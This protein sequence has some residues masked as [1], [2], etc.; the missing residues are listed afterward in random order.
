MQLTHHPFQRIGAHAAA[1]L[2]G[3]RDCTELTAADLDRVAARIAADADRASRAVK[4]GPDW[5]W[6]VRLA[7]MYPQSPP[8]LPR[9]AV[10]AA[11]GRSV[12][13]DVLAQ[14]E[15]DAPDA[16]EPCWACG[17]AASVRWGK[18]HWPLLESARYYNT[19]RGGQP[20]CRECRIAVWALA[21]GAGGNGGRV[22]TVGAFTDPLLEA[23]I[24]QSRT[25]A[26]VAVI[27]S[28]AAGWPDVPVL[29]LVLSALVE[30]PGQI[31]IQSWSNGNREQVF[32]EYIVSAAA[33]GWL[34]AVWRLE[35]G[36]LL[37]ALAEAN[38]GHP[39]HYAQGEGLLLSEHGAEASRDLQVRENRPPALNGALRVLLATRLA[40]EDEGVLDPEEWALQ[41]P[42]PTT[43][44]LKS[45]AQYA[46]SVSPQ[47]DR[48]SAAAG[49]PAKLVPAFG[50]T[51][52]AAAWTR[53]RLCVVSAPTLYQ[54]LAA[55]WEPERALTEPASRGPRRP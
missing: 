22:V 49:R 17:K 6:Y 44:Q 27:D 36:P 4:D 3:R 50:R 43:A 30:R 41:V 24:A 16:A 35:Y 11:D 9:R 40:V 18:S 7:A 20:C 2:A 51:M 32:K 5:A 25:A 29:D 1:A 53:E 15:P 42:P 21:Y 10:F 48:A 33:A 23:A 37:R 55:G 31:E 39:L 8:T 45:I 46:R 19:S 14:F 38:G 26:S 12:H 13:D 54:R 52:S 47:D 34:A 28:H